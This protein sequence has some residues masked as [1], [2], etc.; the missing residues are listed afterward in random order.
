M[1]KANE[2]VTANVIYEVTD[3]NDVE[4]GGRHLNVVER[5]GIE[6]L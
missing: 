6:T 2:V 4:E 5:K 3:Y 1:Q